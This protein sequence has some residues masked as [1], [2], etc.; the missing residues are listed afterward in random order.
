MW[1]KSK[2]LASI[3]R[4]QA[5]RHTAEGQRGLALITA[6]LVLSFLTIIGA[7][8]L[9]T[10]TIDVRISDNYRTSTQ[11]QFLAE[12][13]IEAARETLRVSGNS[14]STDLGIAAGVDGALASTQDLTALLL[15][16][17]QPLLPANNAL[18][19][20][21]QTLLDQSG[22]AI[23][24]Y[25][26]FMRNDAA[27]AGGPASP[28]DTNDVVQLMSIARIGSATKTIVTLV[29]R[30]S[31]PPIPAA[32]TLDGGVGTFDAPSGNNFYVN[33]NDQAGSGNDENAIGVIA[34]NPDI[35]R[36]RTGI[37]NNRDDH[38]LGDGNGLPPPE[39]IANVSG[40]LNPLLTTTAGLESLVSNISAGA[41]DT[42]TPGFGNS[43][44]IGNIGGPND[45]RVVVV[46]GDCDFGPGQGYG[47]LVV[48]GR[49]TT[50]GNFGWNGLILIIGQGDLLWNGGGNRDIQGGVFIAKTRGT[51]TAQEPLGPMLA[52]RGDVSAVFNG[53][54]G[55]GIYYNTTTIRNANGSF[56]YSPISI[57]EY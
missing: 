8:L 1:I 47:I 25:H 24:T 13:G 17:D 18:R 41:T 14:I 42:Y 3:G 33:G 49:L 19:A 39:D 15:T 53:G 30:G 16:D 54:G 32:L 38:Y 11:L 4:R 5:G 43:T 37:P 57:R 52:S 40:D 51:P 9:T 28:A 44:A 12:A 22:R 35:N 36:V 2:N 50:S 46:N 23:G 31:F 10:T 56:P 20:T 26:V 55:N 7:A 27:E 45:Y 21:G 29:K 6:L 34:D 48:R